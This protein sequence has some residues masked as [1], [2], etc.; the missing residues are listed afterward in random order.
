MM[1]FRIAEALQI[2]AELH[3]R[4]KG[5]LL[6]R[7]GFQKRQR[8]LIA[9]EGPSFVTAVE[10]HVRQRPGSCRV[11][12]IPGDGLFIG[13]NGPRALPVLLVDSCKGN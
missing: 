7:V 2:Q 13:R 11:V 8:L 5:L 1:L 6:F 10:E 12:G 4:A 3:H 9:S